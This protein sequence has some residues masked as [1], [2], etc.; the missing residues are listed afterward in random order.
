M[1]GPFSL[2]PDETVKSSLA[3][4]MGNSGTV[5]N[6]PDTADVMKNARTAQQMYQRKYQGSGPPKT[7]N[8]TASPDNKSVRL[9][10]D[11]DAESSVDVLTGKNDFEGYKVYRSDDQ[12]K[13]WGAPITD[14]SG[15]VVGY[16][17]LKIFDLVD[18]IKRTGSGI[19]SVTG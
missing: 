14:A 6:S 18:G 15:N 11:A 9:S 19:Q 4:V 3:V 1:T 10:W 2:Q 12:G 5:V 16:K 13:T 17:P 8:V 7:P